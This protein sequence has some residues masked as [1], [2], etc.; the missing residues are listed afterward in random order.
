MLP[1]YRFLLS[2]TYKGTG[3]YYPSP[4]QPGRSQ[5]LSGIVQVAEYKAI[6][7]QNLYGT[8]VE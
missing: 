3:D 4:I 1:F 7:I 5:H 8:D 2:K 6:S